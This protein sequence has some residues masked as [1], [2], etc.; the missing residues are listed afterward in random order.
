LTRFAVHS[1]ALM[2]ALLPP[3]V[4]ADIDPMALL[5]EAR[6]K[7]VENVKRLPKYTCVQTVHRSRFETRLRRI[8]LLRF[9]FGM[10]DTGPSGRRPNNRLIPNA[11]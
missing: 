6:A 10:E 8:R 3:A 4:C 7:I 11:N 1:A 5:N 2:G 9:R